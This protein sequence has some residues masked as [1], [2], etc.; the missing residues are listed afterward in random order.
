MTVATMRVEGAQ[1]RNL[2]FFQLILRGFVCLHYGGRLFVLLCYI[3]AKDPG[4]G[5]FENV[6]ILC[7]Y[8]VFESDTGWK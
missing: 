3:S 1:K 2:F 6:A 7:T 8:F 4:T 5:N